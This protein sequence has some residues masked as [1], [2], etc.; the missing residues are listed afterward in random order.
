VDK[1]GSVGEL[2]VLTSPDKSLSNEVL[3]L[4]KQSPDWIPAIQYN[5]N[6]IYRHIQAITFRLE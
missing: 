3:R 2:N 4:M 1:D 6:V 5:K